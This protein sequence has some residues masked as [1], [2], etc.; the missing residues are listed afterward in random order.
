MELFFVE[1]GDL[2]AKYSV[3]DLEMIDLSVIPEG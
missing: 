1:G 3:I 2:K